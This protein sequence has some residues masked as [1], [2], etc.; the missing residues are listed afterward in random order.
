[1]TEENPSN[2]DNRL[3]DLINLRSRVIEDLEKNRK[4][5]AE[6]EATIASSNPDIVTRTVSSQGRTLDASNIGNVSTGIPRLDDLLS[7]GFSQ[8][9]NVLLT[10]PPYSSKF[11][12]ADNFIASS[13]ISGYP[14]I[15]VS[16]D[17]DISSLR[18]DL[19]GMGL[20]IESY[21]KTGLLKFVDAYSRNIQ[22]ESDNRNATVID[23]A[24]N[25]SLFLKTMDTICN[26]VVSG[27]GRYSMVFFS[28]T[29]WIT[30]SSDD[31]N[32]PKAFQ[33]F[34]QRRKLEGATTLYLIEDGIFQRSLYEN[35]NYF[36]DG[37]IEFRSEASTEYLR[38]R[39]L[40]HV[41]SRDWIE[42][43]N[44]GDG[45]SL[46]SFELKRIK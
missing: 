32:F 15:V 2:P 30:Q 31:K 41:R 26:S 4:L 40:K 27:F 13:L 33:H 39:G 12:V 28:L 36:M 44:N 20:S 10:G 42:I 38:V 7:G 9:S 43:A 34:S 35:L 8:S 3:Q 19:S 45:I 22:M 5:L 37:A 46:G 1:M 6:I 25:V 29:G 23:N 11:M 21:E 18:E 24:G 14:V 16:L 17:R